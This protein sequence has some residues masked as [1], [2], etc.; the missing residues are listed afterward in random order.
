M[1]LNRTALVATMLAATSLL[2]H[3]AG[4]NLLKWNAK[5]EDAQGD[6]GESH[7]PAAGDLAAG[8]RRL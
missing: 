7:W 5:A 2:S 6:T 4:A 1:S 3:C 8:R